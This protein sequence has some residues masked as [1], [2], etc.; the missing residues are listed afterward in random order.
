[1]SSMTTLS[2]IGPDYIVISGNGYG[3][4]EVQNDRHREAERDR[5]RDQDRLWASPSG[6]IEVAMVP[7][8]GALFSAT[9][10]HVSLILLESMNPHNKMPVKYYTV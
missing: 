2:L 5:S 3:W 4:P 9:Y 10:N 1:M 8:I 6:K 7:G